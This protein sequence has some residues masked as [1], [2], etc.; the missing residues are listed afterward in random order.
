MHQKRICISK[1][2]RRISRF[3]LLL[4]LH[5]QKN[6]SL[7]TLQQGPFEK[8]HFFSEIFKPKRGFF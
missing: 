6:V 5:I 2:Q 3:K 7:A 8:R 4:F 1:L